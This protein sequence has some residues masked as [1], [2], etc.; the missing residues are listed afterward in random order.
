MTQIT[1]ELA[2]QYLLSR[3]DGLLSDKE[4]LFLK[5]HL[6]GCETCRLEEERLDHL[7]IQLQDSFR[8]RWDAIS[9]PARPLVT[10]LPAPESQWPRFG[11]VAI[12]LALFALW[13]WLYRAVLDYLKIIF[14]HEE[15]R[16]NQ[17]LLAGVLILI[18][19]QF[20]KQRFQ[21]KVDA[22]PQMYAPG[23]GLMIGGSAIYL[24]I[25]RILDI[26]TL[27]ATLFGLATYG[28]LGLW[29]SPRRWLEGLP[30]ALLL[31]GVL[32]FGDHLETF[33]G[34]PMRLATAWIVQNGFSILGIHSVGVDTILILESGLA[35]VDIPCSGVKSLWTGML[36]LIAATWLE[37]RSVNLRWLGI[38]WLVGGMLFVANVARVAVLVVVDTLAGW[39]I[40]AELIHVPLGVL[41]FSGVCGIAVLL[42]RSQP[43]LAGIPFADPLNI[44]GGESSVEK[45]RPVWLAPLLAVLIAGMAL[46]YQPRPQP[47][48]A[49]AAVQ[50]VFP[51]EL[52]VHTDSL[53]PELFAWLTQDG[54]VFA[55]RWQFNWGAEESSLSGDLMFITSDNW[56]GQHKPERCFEVQGQ[57]VESVQTVMVAEDFS[58]RVLRLS[59]G[60]LQVSALYWLQTGN[61]VT[62]DF[63]TR[64][65]SDLGREKPH[66][67]LVT[68]LLDDV[69]PPDSAS[70]GALAN[71]VR[72]V[73]AEGFGGNELW[74]K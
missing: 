54:V 63:A 27:S 42:V 49:Q 67:V 26:N 13:I 65:W 17:F 43:Q 22:L 40:L 28:F 18:Y 46:L 25:E 8:E 50:W 60:P 73:V 47:V 3:A 59:R 16:T 56:R 48:A 66:W 36:F 51:S 1:H 15:F 58:L 38:V 23:L 44:L 61:R 39:G 32:P 72:A 19:V 71:T 69:Y 35:Q 2:R 41:A 57:K 29:I 37:G 6:R 21:L 20:R 45:K 14:S 24:I 31:I 7:H 62:D 53:S 70:L 33:I 12:N 74:I 10:S 30:A 64:I 11:R 5:E 68:I 52:Q 9:P 55:D 4:N 34:Y